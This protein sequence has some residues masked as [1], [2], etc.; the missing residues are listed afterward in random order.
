MESPAGIR[1]LG[2]RQLAAALSRNDYVFIL[3]IA[4]TYRAASVSERA[5]LQTNCARSLAVAA[6]YADVLPFLYFVVYCR[7]PI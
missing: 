5:L 6:L 2:V 3:R 7:V 1:C 4:R